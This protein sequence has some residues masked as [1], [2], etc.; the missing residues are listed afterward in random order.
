[1]LAWA[2]DHLSPDWEA[3]RERYFTL[4]WIRAGVTWIAFGL[5]LAA[6]IVAL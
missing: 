1:M 4:N 2:P 6:L 5:F 3:T